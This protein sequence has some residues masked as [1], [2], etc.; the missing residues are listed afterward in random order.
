MDL[1]TVRDFVSHPMRFYGKD[2][3]FSAAQV[4]QNP[5]GDYAP[6]STVIQGIL[7][8]M[9]DGFTSS[10][11]QA[12]A[13]EAT[14]AK[15]FEALFGT[16]ISELDTLKATLAK[17]T[18]DAANSKKNLADTKLE[19]E[20][21]KKQLE[22]D[23]KFFEET[24]EACKSKAADW[25][26]RSRLRTE[27]LAGMN[28][29]IEILSSDEAMATFD[30]AH[31]TF[32]Q[33]SSEVDNNHMSTAMVRQ[34]KAFASLKSVASRFRSLRLASLAAT[35][36]AAEGGHF[37]KVIVMID[38]MIQTL[39]AEEQED[40]E[41]RDW[42]EAKDNKYKNQKED[43]EY[44]IGQT[45]GLIERLTAKS[46]EMEEQIAATQAD[47]TST[48]EAMEEALAQRN[49]ES[50]DFK[51][52]LKDDTDAVALLAQENEAPT[53]FYTNNKIPLGLV[54]KKAPEYTVDPDKAPETPGFEKPYG[55]RKSESTG[56]IAILSMIKEDLENE[57]V[58][59]K[60]AETAAA[61]EFAEMRASSLKT[62]EA[63]KEKKTEQESAKA[64]IDGK[65]EEA[66]ATKAE[67]EAMK[68]EKNEEIE[69][70]TPNCEWLKTAFD[71]RREKRKTEIDALIEAK[72][73]LAGANSE[74]AAETAEL[75][76]KST[77]FLPKRA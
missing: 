58:E 30:R 36:R 57:I 7:K 10:L 54:Q 6:Q 40:I 5:F 16:K 73:V 43:M 46:N 44:K 4:K 65:K 27:E 3:K 8:E 56:I 28:K 72:G 23:E 51:D 53:D 60:K 55:G 9:Y 77:A 66:E 11:E 35:V 74:E 76:Q 14:K 47:I 25:A 71:S 2:A 15:E 1:R 75:V 42:C 37:D 63:L 41:N 26:E 21:T 33:I 29:A 48:E 62:L 19:L 18:E 34:N 31:S 20:A 39:R 50:Q 64:D 52:A 13:D 68:D 70:I 12:N 38:K 32:L 24:K 17:K 61:A 69:S 59:G 22:E 67:T 45:E 49:Q